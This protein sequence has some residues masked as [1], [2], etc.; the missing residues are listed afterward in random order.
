MILE[1]YIFLNHTC[2]YFKIIQTIKYTILCILIIQV[3]LKD[4]IYQKLYRDRYI[5]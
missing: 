2:S 1:K 4:A 5:V 3:F